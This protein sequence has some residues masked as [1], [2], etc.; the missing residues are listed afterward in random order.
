M[1]DISNCCVEPDYYVGILSAL[2]HLI[3]HEQSCLLNE[4]PFKPDWPLDLKSSILLLFKLGMQVEQRGWKSSTQG[5]NSNLLY[6]CIAPFHKYNQRMAGDITSLYLLVSV[7]IFWVN[8]GNK[9]YD[10]NQ[11]KDIE[12]SLIIKLWS[13]QIFCLI[14]SALCYSQINDEDWCTYISLY[15]KLVNLRI[16]EV[17][18]CCRVTS[19][20]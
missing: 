2:A 16:R 11:I 18:V 17:V 12:F 9:K 10:K 3:G 7:C 5:H 15:Q 4:V 13:K 19:S 1:T 6:F 8:T 20:I 14:F